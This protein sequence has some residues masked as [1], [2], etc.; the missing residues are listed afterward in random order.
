MKYIQKLIRNLEHQSKKHEDETYN[1]RVPNLWNTCYEKGVKTYD[2]DLIVNPYSFYYENIKKIVADARRLNYLKPLSVIHGQRKNDQDWIHRAFA[3]SAMIRTSA[4]YDHDHDGYITQKD[5]YGF[6]ETGTFMKFIVL[7]PYL[8]EIGIDTLY[9]LPFF[10]GS[11]FDKKGDFSSCYAV[12]DF[13]SIDPTLKDPLLDEMDV[14]AECKAFMEACHLMGM[15]VTID[16]IPRTNA[17]RSALLKEHPDWF[18]WIS[19]ERKNEYKPPEYAQLPAISVA[20]KEVNE[21]V[22][23]SLQTYDF[24]SLFTFDPRTIDATKYAQ[25]VAKSE[26]ENKDLLSLIEEQ[27]GITVACAFSD[28]ANDPQPVWSDVTYL[29]MYIDHP[30]QGQ[31]YVSKNHPPYILF[32]VAKC[33]LNPGQLPN[34]ELW[35]MISDI[36]PYYQ[37]NYGID[38]VRIDMGHALPIDLVTRIIA[39]AKDIDPTCAIIAEEL[40]TNNDRISVEKGYSM[41]LGNGFSEECR[42]YE[43]RLNRFY[44]H[45]RTMACPLFAS[46]ETHDT[47]R[48]AAREGEKKLARM[49]TIL[50]LFMPNGVAF[51]NSGQEFYEVQPMN[52]GLD[53]TNEE[54]YRLG[55]KDYR[56]GKLALFDAFAFTYEKTDL[57]ALLKKA[58]VN[59][60]QYIEA[61]V[62]VRQNAPAWFDHPYDLGIGSFFFKQK[63]ILLAVANANIYEEATYHVQWS[64][65]EDQLR[66][67]PKSLKLLLSTEDEELKC[68]LKENCIEIVLQPCEIK[69]IECS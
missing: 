63:K 35:E 11:D 22:Y 21:I 7:L 41:I 69:L 2:G 66:F 34:E 53:A 46:A 14:E 3:Y 32:D 47:P 9:L 18:Y 28:Q 29:R 60:Q 51:L 62:D 23:Q 31:H 10:A 58:T 1:Y 67:K 38:G 50:N 59:R 24:L 17:I 48:I 37:Q 6:K 64:N 8:K 52:L 54:R 26:S 27:F 20:T 39:K 45:A 65:I 68:E 55:K 33:S 19:L 4:S 16:I 44:Y 42:I 49:L 15:R 12:S 61:I 57:L 36:I 30:C 25:V 56:Y 43:H 5:L 40:D 13:F